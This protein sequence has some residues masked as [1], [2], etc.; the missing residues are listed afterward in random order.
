MAS[1]DLTEREVQVLALIHRGL[2]EKEIGREL[3]ISPKTVNTHRNNIYRAL[4]VHT[5]VEA[6]VWYER[7]YYD[8]HL[9]VRPSAVA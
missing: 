8:R 2:S 7:N 6:A 5:A 9:Y 1:A 4:R 3:A